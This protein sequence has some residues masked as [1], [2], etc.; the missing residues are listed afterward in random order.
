MSTFQLE[1]YAIFILIFGEKLGTSRGLT[2][3]AP[4]WLCCVVFV[5]A[6]DASGL[7]VLL[8]ADPGAEEKSEDR[9]RSPRTGWRDGGGGWGGRVRG[10]GL[11]R[12]GSGHRDLTRA[13]PMGNRRCAFMSVKKEPQGR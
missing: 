8:D 6:A 2:G 10:G 12:S 7:H 9:G 5:A 11:G 13:L 1:R 4:V 3:A